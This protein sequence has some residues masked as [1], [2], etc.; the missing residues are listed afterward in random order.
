LSSYVTPVAPAVAT[1]ATL[2]DDRFSSL[3]SPP[4]LRPPN[5]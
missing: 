4:L 2:H 5:A 1:G 3:P